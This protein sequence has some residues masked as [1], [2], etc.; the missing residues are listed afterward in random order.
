MSKVLFIS[1]TGMTES[2]GCSQVLEYLIDL[3]K[4]NKI[5]L[6]SFEREDDS[7]TLKEI[8][9]MTEKFNIEWKYLI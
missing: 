7:E 5:Y 1:L 9:S 2:L 4:E 6:I 3:S 8:K